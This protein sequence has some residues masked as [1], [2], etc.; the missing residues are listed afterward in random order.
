MPIDLDRLNE[1]LKDMGPLPA[2]HVKKPKRTFYAIPG[3]VDQYPP[4][5]LCKEHA[6]YFANKLPKQD[7]DK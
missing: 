4:P 1:N 3:V 2:A 5:R 7:S 6:K